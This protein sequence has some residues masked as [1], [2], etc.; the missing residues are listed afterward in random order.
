MNV[1]KHVSAEPL[2]D[3]MQGCD[4]WEVKVGEHGLVA[5]V[6]IMPRLVPA[7]RTADIAIV[8]AARTSTGKGAKSPGED[9]GLIRYLYSHM[10]TSPF[11][12][13]NV[14][15][16]HVLPIFVARQLI[17][18]RTASV[19]EY[20]LRYAQPKDR[21]WFPHAS[22]LRT[23]STSNKQVTNGSVDLNMAENFIDV[24]EDTSREAMQEYQTAIAAGIGREQARTILPL[25]LFTEWFWEIDLKNL[26]GFLGL[27]QDKHAQAEIRVYADAMYDLLK[28]L[29]PDALE[30]YDD[31][32]PN[33]LGMS[34]S[35]MDIEAL[36][37][38]CTPTRILELFSSNREL[39][40]FTEKARRI[41]NDSAVEM[42]ELGMFIRSGESADTAPQHEQL[43]RMPA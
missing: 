24:L 5:L 15:F 26:L 17:R 9:R 36:N 33:R 42:A 16:H 41:G 8:Q 40:E 13:V 39:L 18:H 6:D 14:K 34:L 32:H 35:R 31:Y 4:R 23:Q 7:N 10:H 12:M 21:F 1:V 29:V 2:V 3:L 11:E 25:N 43:A 22:Q 38:K 28:T 19:N 30:A 27:R 37:P 20:S